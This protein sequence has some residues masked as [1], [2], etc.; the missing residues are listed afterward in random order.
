VAALASLLLLILRRADYLWA[1]TLVSLAIVLYQFLSE[2][3]CRFPGIAWGV[4]SERPVL[5]WAVI[6]L[7]FGIFLLLL[8]NYLAFA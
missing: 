7:E 8:E 1:A 2:S 5:Y 4:R 3:L 6:A